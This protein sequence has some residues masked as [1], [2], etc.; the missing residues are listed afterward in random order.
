M[1][2][3][4]NKSFKS[5]LRA[6]AESYTERPLNESLEDEVES[7]ILNV[8]TDF[9]HKMQTVMVEQI[10][11]LLNKMTKD[12]LPNLELMDIGFNK[13][14]NNIKNKRYAINSKDMLSLFISDKKSSKIEDKNESYVV[15]KAEFIIECLSTF[16]SEDFK[17]K[18]K[19]LFGDEIS[20]DD[21]KIK[22]IL[23]KYLIFRTL[24]NAYIT[25]ENEYL[26]THSENK[27]VELKA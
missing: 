18:A 16:N 22:S 10:K 8:F 6:W 7:K 12:D 4:K 11:K 27:N 14:L 1:I 13:L 2:L 21:L 26:K 9:D 17:N 25:S 24:L 15:T 20:N 23:I 3:S 5:Q 19:E